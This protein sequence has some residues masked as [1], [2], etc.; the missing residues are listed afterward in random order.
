MRHGESRFALFEFV[1]MQMKGF[2]DRDGVELRA[3]GRGKFWG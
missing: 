2:G 3:N 1:Q